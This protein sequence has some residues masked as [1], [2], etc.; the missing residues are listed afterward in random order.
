MDA[1]EID[2]L[3]ESLLSTDIDGPIVEVEGEDYIEGIRDVNYCLAGKVLSKKWVNRDAFRTVIEQLWSS[4]GR[5]EVEAAGENLFVFHFR[6]V[7]ERSMVWVR[8]PWYFDGSLIVLEKLTDFW[9]H[10]YNISIICMKG[11]Q[12]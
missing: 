4:I 7:E 12:R 10:I 11:L 2:R 5:V 8:G 9:V 6:R 3:C 1:E